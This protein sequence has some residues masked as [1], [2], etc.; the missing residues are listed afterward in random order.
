MIRLFCDRCG[1]EIKPK[2]AVDVKISAK[3]RWMDKTDTWEEE[4]CNTCAFRL[5]DWLKKVSEPNE[6]L[7]PCRYKPE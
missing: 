2:E 7:K 5:G 1:Q 4:V 3:R 6:C